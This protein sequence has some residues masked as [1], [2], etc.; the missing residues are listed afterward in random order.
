[1]THHSTRPAFAANEHRAWYSEIGDRIPANILVA[2][3]VAM[4]VLYITMDLIASLSYDGYSYTDQTISELSA[5]GAPTR[6]MWNAFSV[7]Y[8]VLT[9]AFAFGVLRVAGQ[10][11]IIRVIGWLL[12]TFAAI[13]LL[14]WFG[15]MHRREELAAGGGDWRDTLHL[16]VG[17]MNSLLFFALTGVGMFAFGRWFRWYSIATIAAMVIFGTLM[18]TDV[19]AVRDNEPTP[20]LGIWER[21]AVEGAMLWLA[22][23]AAVLLWEHRRPGERRV[24][25]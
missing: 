19:G 2:S 16:V 9:F 22:V 11:R 1:M 14:W 15:P 18:N 24:E 20:W 13:N 21:I 5:I 4:F 10:R 3:G 23:F 25:G 17:G 7:V 12:L 8:Q 6:G